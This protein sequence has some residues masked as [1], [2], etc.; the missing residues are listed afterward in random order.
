[1]PPW[2]K[3]GIGRKRASGGAGGSRRGTALVALTA[4]RKAGAGAGAATEPRRCARQPR[5]RRPIRAINAGSGS[6]WQRSRPGAGGVGKRLDD[7]GQSGARAGARDFGLGASGSDA[8]I[9]GPSLPKLLAIR[10]AAADLG[11][12]SG[13]PITL[14]A[15]CDVDRFRSREN[16]DDLA[17]PHG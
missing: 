5:A 1:M 12:H 17:R 8:D 10:R 4:E 7:G 3:T 11:R 14:W 9:Y 6:H 16:P 13:L 2:C 15:D